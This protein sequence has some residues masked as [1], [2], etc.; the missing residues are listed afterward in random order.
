[1]TAKATLGEAELPAVPEKSRVFR[2]LPDEQFRKAFE[3]L[4]SKKD[5]SA[6]TSF[7]SMKLS[8][9][10]GNKWRAE[11]E[12]RSTQGKKDTKVFTGARDEIKKAILADKDL[13]ANERTH[14]LRALNLQDPVFEFHFPAWE[15]MP[16][17][18]WD[19]P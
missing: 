4:E 17:E 6:W 8:R 13:P 18:F 9:L 11:I 12:Y 5:E 19:R 1:M 7:D 10:E 14:L 2:L 16:S 3:D 15:S